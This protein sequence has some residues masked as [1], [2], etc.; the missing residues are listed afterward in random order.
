MCSDAGHRE[1]VPSFAEIRALI[2]A[3]FLVVTTI[4]L[5]VV[6]CTWLTKTCGWIAK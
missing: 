4:A 6:A 3:A 2:G 5:T 1:T